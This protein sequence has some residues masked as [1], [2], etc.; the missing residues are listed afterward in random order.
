MAADSYLHR[1]HTDFSVVLLGFQFQLHIEQSDLWIFV[2][3]GLHLKAGVGERLLECNARDQLGLLNNLKNQHA[4][5][6][7]CMIYYLLL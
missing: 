7:P 3:F 6:R 2:A 1:F 5:V 4:E